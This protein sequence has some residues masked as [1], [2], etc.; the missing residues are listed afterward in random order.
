MLRNGKKNTSCLFTA[1]IDC[2]SLFFFKEEYF[3]HSPICFF[4]EEYIKEKYFNHS[5]VTRSTPHSPCD[6]ILE[7][8]TQNGNKTTNNSFFYEAESCT[9][10][11]APKHVYLH[12][13]SA[14]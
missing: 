7:A 10:R 12:P 5:P 13:R 3:N 11:L 4:K 14:L 1:R 2:F 6:K 9:P 8:C